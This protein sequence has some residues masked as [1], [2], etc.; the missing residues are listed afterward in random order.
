MENIDNILLK[1]I[2]SKCNKKD[3]VNN[4]K[5]LYNANVLTNDETNLIEKA[6]NYMQIYNNVD[7]IKLFKELNY[8]YTDLENIEEFNYSQMLESINNLITTR[9]EVENQNLINESLSLSA[10]GIYTNK[11]LDTFFNRYINEIK[12]EEDNTY[13]EL[14]S[15]NIKKDEYVSTLNGYIDEITGGLANGSITS[16]VGARDICK[17]IWSLNIAYKCLADNKNVLYI[18]LETKK[19]DIYKRLLSRHSCETKFDNKLTIMEL[20]NEEYLDEY[21][22]VYDDFEKNLLKNIVVFDKDDFNTMS[23]Y[24]MQMLIAHSNNQ[25]LKRNNN[26][27]DLIVIDGFLNMIIEERNKT[28]TNRNHVIN[29]YYKYLK[30]QANNLLGFNNQIPIIITMDIRRDAQYLIEHSMGTHDEFNLGFVEDEAITLSDNIYAVYSDFNL[31]KQQK[32]RYKVLKSAKDIMEES[33]LGNMD[34]D[35]YYIEDNYYNK[36]IA[37]LEQ[38]DKELTQS[39]TD[40]ITSNNV[41]YSGSQMDLLD[42]DIFK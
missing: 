5:Y 15:I 10:Q 12:I 3:Y 16:I 26:T 6:L 40:V 13:K 17:S 9:R 31:R 22:K 21:H 33:K 38:E 39:M 2:N 23:I 28:I 7:L 19:E 29:Y 32:A 34:F 24:N 42:L 27:I 30:T 1:I 25:F 11:T 36:D 18:S 37:K 8:D 14:Y 41:S 20:S 35:H 4:I